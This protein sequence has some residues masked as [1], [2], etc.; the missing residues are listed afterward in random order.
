M[1]VESQRRSWRFAFKKGGVRFHPN[2]LED[3]GAVDHRWRWR[4][5]TT[6]SVLD[7]GFVESAGSSFTSRT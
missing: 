6:A 4:L 1:G 3:N 5:T 7:S 2:L